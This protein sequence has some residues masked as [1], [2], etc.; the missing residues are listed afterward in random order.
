MAHRVLVSYSYTEFERKRIVQEEGEQRSDFGKD[1]LEEDP[2]MADVQNVWKHFEPKKEE[3]NKNRNALRRSNT[4]PN[5]TQPQDIMLR[6][7][8]QVWSEYDATF[9][10]REPTWIFSP[11]TPWEGT[12]LNHL[13][14]HC[15]QQEQQENSVDDYQPTVVFYFHT[16]GTSRYKPTWR[17]QLDQPYTYSRVLYWRKYMEA[18]LLER[19]A[20]CRDKILRDG[21]LTCGVDHR[22]TGVYAGNFWAASCEYLAA[23]PELEIFVSRNNNKIQDKEHYFDMEHTFGKAQR[24]WKAPQRFV[25]LHQ[26][27]ASLKG[28]YYRL[29]EPTEYSERLSDLEAKAKG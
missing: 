9:R 20:H 18:F 6:A 16:K 22:T 13:R 26:P 27:N 24:Q 10:V 12:I 3:S 25:S 8:Q 2:A 1:D 5:S 23:L 15:T 19:P 29:M 14:Q 17:G 11:G 4:T 28:L 21:A 7:L